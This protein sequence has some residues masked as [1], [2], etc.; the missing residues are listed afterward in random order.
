MASNLIPTK[1]P[2]FGAHRDLAIENADA[3][4]FGAPHGTPYPDI[5]NTLFAGAAD[6]LRGALKDDPE[7]IDNW[8]FDLGGPLLAETDFKVADVGNLDT[9]PLDAE[10]NRSKIAETTARIV[11]LGGV[12]LMIGGDDSTP[13]PFIEGLGAAG[14]LT[15]LQVDAHIDWRDERYGE[16]LGFSS[17]MRRASEMPHVERII[18]VGMRG[19]GSARRGE[20]EFAQEWGASLI[21]ARRVFAEGLA[22]ILDLI[23]A[24][25][26]TMITL[27]CD[28]LD[29]SII[30]AV[31]APTPGGL[32]YT[33]AIDLVAG[34]T[35]RAKLVGFDII[36]FAPE[37]DIGGLGA[38]TA[39]RITANVIGCLA[40]E[41]SKS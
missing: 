36:E 22:P 32:S 15:I 35:E 18:Q 21:P 30:P 40:R 7:F 37:K 16:P 11:Q 9:A 1:T 3:V 39:A 28:G 31:V 12:P 8:D 38:I 17:T 20:V 14:P 33:H 10:G 2:F 13:I 19:L 29:P 24:G 27:D 25:A 26:N 34:V 6:A 5:D 41:K 4:I 23:P